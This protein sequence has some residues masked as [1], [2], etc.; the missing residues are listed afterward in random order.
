MLKKLFASFFLT[1]LSGCAST[2]L[3]YNAVDISSTISD[4]YTRQALNN[5]AKFIDDRNA[6]PSQVILSTGTVQTLNTV[7]PS[8][9]FP[10]TAQVA[11]ALSTAATGALSSA[12]T[13]TTSGAGA[14]ASFS[15]SQQQNYNIAPLSDALALRNQQSIYRRAV[16]GNNIVGEFTPPRLFTRD[17]FI[18]DPYHLQYPQCVLCAKK[19]GVFVALTSLNSNNIKEN[20]KLAPSWLRWDDPA[21]QSGGAQTIKDFKYLG[22]FVNHDL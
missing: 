9:T 13:R 3:N 17:Q 19:Q 15:N 16:Y 1:T 22:R 7:N 6:I 8:V 12:N 5:L 14:T 4:V 11:N 18:F 21:K 10:L 2:Q 20:K